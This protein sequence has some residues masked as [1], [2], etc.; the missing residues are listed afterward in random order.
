[1]S[2]RRRDVTG[3]LLGGGQRETGAGCG[4]DFYYLTAISVREQQREAKKRHNA[5][6][7]QPLLPS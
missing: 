6:L 5:N 1:M 3:Y 4:A 7:H 2:S